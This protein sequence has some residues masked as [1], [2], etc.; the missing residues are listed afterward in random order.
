MKEY[1]LNILGIKKIASAFIADA[2]GELSLN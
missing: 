2:F 1:V